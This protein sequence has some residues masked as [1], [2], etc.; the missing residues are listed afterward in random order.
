MKAVKAR[1]GRHFVDRPTTARLTLLVNS[2]G[3]H[4]AAI[5]GQPGATTVV[6]DAMNIRDFGRLVAEAV[7]ERSMLQRVKRIGQPLFDDRSPGRCPRCGRALPVASLDNPTRLVGTGAMLLPRT[8][9][10]RVHACLV[11]GPRAADAQGDSVDDTLRAVAFVGEA[12]GAAGWRKWANELRCADAETAGQ[13]LE[14]LRLSGPAP[15]RGMR[16]L[17]VLV[18]TLGRF[19]PTA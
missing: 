11:D 13:V 1:G 8:D 12:L 3:G 15:L 17:G 4:D 19:W 7:P 16:E 14:R 10:E 9:A 6:V 5:A 18:A 2:L